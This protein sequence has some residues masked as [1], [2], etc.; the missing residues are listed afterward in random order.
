MIKSDNI[1]PID[2]QIWPKELLGRRLEMAPE[3]ELD[4]EPPRFDEVE[5]EEKLEDCR[6]ELEEEEEEPDELEE[7]PYELENPDPK[8]D[9]PDPDPDVS[10]AANLSPNPDPD[11]PGNPTPIPPTAIL[12]PCCPII[13]VKPELPELEL[14][15]TVTVVV[16][17]PAPPKF[18]GGKTKGMFTGAPAIPEIAPPVISETP[19]LPPEM[20]FEVFEVLEEI[21]V[22]P[23]EPE[24][25]D[26]D[27]DE[28]DDAT[29]DPEPLVPV[30]PL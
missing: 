10:N 21:T 22:D 1:Y 27:D 12:D 15:V 16:V 14:S 11:D 23:L 9:N 2:H 4:I 6:E 26:D 25:E 18:D 24:L 30:L 5:F 3:I 13:L 19:M 8:P 29:L 17:C 7:E 28:F 20:T